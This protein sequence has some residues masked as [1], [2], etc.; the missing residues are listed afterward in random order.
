MTKKK[1]ET[2]S[3]LSN[4][5]LL[6][7]DLGWLHRT[8]RRQ[9]PGLGKVLYQGS[10]HRRISPQEVHGLNHHIRKGFLY[11]MRSDLLALTRTRLRGRPYSF[12]RN[13]PL[14]GCPSQGRFCRPQAL[15]RGRVSTHRGRGRSCSTSC[16]SSW[17]GHLQVSVQGRLTDAVGG[18]GP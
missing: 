10:L 1:R 8:G 4:G 7:G 17:Q 18:L 6:F 9:V 13:R 16:L 11:W 3:H 14:F 2:Q 15:R 5:H 12:I